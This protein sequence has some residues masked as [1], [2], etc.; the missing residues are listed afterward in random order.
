MTH[1]VRIERVSNGAT[2]QTGPMVTRRG[3]LSA[4]ERGDYRE[5]EYGA[6]RVIVAGGADRRFWPDTADVQMLAPARISRIWGQASSDGAFAVLEFIEGDKYSGT[7]VIVSMDD[8]DA[9]AASLANSGP[10]LA[11]RAKP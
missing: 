11:E 6:P 3:G 7:K 2:V 4:F 8:L 5:I 9:L 10:M 1:H